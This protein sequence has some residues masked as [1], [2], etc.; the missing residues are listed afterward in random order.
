MVN[1]KVWWVLKTA[2]RF[3]LPYILVN[4]LI[5]SLS[6][7]VVLF[8]N[9]VN[10]N[11]V[12]SLSAGIDAGELPK[13][14]FILVFV[15]IILYILYFTFGFIKAFGSNFYRLNVDLLFHKI[16]MYKSYATSQE[17]FFDHE[18]MEKYSFVSGNTS[19]ISSYIGSLTNLIFSNIGFIVGTVLMFAVYEPFFVIYSLIIGILA[20][21]VKRYIAKKE[22]EL[23]KRQIKELR[24]HDYYKEVLTGKP[25][26]KELR[27]YRFKDHIFRKWIKIYDA[28][29]LEKLN[30]AL[31]KVSLNNLF[32]VVK[33]VLRGAAIILLLRGVYHKR[34]DLGTFALLFGLIE[35]VFNNIDRLMTNMISGAHKDTKYLTDY[36]DFIMPVTVKEI[37]SIKNTQDAFGSLPFGEFR[38][39]T[40]HNASYTYPNS[41]KKAVDNVSFSLKKGEIVSI[42]GY[43]GSGKTT[44]CK[45]MTGSL[46]LTE[47]RIFL[48]GVPVCE[49]NKEL[50]FQYF[51]IAPQEFS[52]FSIP[53]RDF[54][55]LGS[56]KDKFDEEKLFDAY[57]KAGI[58]PLINKYKDKDRTVLGKEY[59]E[60]GVD[61][62]GGE[63]QSLVIASAYMGEPEILLMDEPTASID[64]LKEM[65]LIGNLRENLKGK[66]AVLISHRIGFA[67]LA[68][69]IIM[70]QDGKITEEGTHE[71]LLA[72]GGY[73]A[74]LFNEQKK[75]YTEEK[76]A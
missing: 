32:S 38:E 19:K 20:F 50:V 1:K 66:T 18:F 54:V 53:L 26:A 7:G 65:E 6:T 21:T 75:L 36:Y 35:T 70:M 60:E 51:G 56:I 30:L 25:T 55:G 62:S 28:L 11:I 41:D 22:Y 31:K 42:L 61:L 64:P 44:L 10:K 37:K 27:I 58:L 16:F 2:L 15:Y 43:N 46:P 52:R 73:Y 45:L 76:S 69:R 8:I 59:D 71:E 57:K 9:I 34:Y 67:R 14:F 63:W 48:N 3:C 39:L 40:I 74:S 4:I 49:G 72:L 13:V 5:V 47:G 29:R 68:D 17:R 23:D 24:Y 33:Y 12:N